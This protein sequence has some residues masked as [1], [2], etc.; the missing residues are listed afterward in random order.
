MELEA[1]TDILRETIWIS[2]FLSAPVLATALATGLAISIFQA[3]TQV[4]EQTLTF[5]P[6]IVL[7]LVVF[8]VTF[9][10]MMQTLTEFTRR[11]LAT[12]AAP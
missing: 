2:L 10:N 12:G 3:A 8:G 9:P 7:T 4:N 6:K 1:V 11:L 5:V